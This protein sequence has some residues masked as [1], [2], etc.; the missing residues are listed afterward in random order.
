MEGLK[1]KY[2]LALASNRSENSSCGLPRDDAFHIFRD[3]LTSD[4][5]WPGILF[6]MSIPSLWYWCTDQVQTSWLSER[7]PGGFFPWGA[8]DSGFSS[9]HLLL[10]AFPAPLPPS[11]TT[12]FLHLCV[13]LPLELAHVGANPKLLIFAKGNSFL[14]E[15]EK[16]RVQVRKGQRE[17][18]EKIT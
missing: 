4:L 13:V 15:R 12:S 16:Q 14:S 8:G 5:P 7:P 3:P 11:S 2:F 9:L 1:E 6:G 17:R 18:G 10:F